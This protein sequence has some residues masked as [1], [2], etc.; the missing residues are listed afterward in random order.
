[1]VQKRHGEGFDPL[2]VV[3]RLH[4][5]EDYMAAAQELVT[6]QGASPNIFVTT[7]DG[8]VIDKVRYM[9]EEAEMFRF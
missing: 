4:P 3:C 1:M 9:V 7:D 6:K 5:W 2:N 8:G